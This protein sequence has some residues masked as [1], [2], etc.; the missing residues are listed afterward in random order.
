MIDLIRDKGLNISQRI[1]TAKKTKDKGCFYT[2]K[3]TVFIREYRGNKLAEIDAFCHSHEDYEILIP[4]TPLPCLV[5]DDEVVFG[6]VGF[7]Y[8]IPSFKKHGF[9]NTLSDVSYIIVVFQRDYFFNV[10]NKMKNPVGAMKS[11]FCSNIIK[12][13]IKMFQS[14]FKQEYELKE[15]MLNTIGET[16]IMEMIRQNLVEYKT[17]IYKTKEY[18]KGIQYVVTFMNNNYS[19]DHSIDTLAKMC[20]MSKYHFIRSFKKFT[21]VP[22][23]EYLYKIRC[24]RAKYLFENTNKKIKEVAKIVGFKS[25]SSFVQ[26]FKRYVGLTPYKYI[27]QVKNGGKN[28]N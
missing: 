25:S 14:I 13:L 22:P 28:E 17:V 20:G 23:L 11:F 27:S 21:S 12:D 19:Q 15:E 9:N 1:E 26:V 4:I 16:L 10:V 7:C 24:S 3:G 18:Q 6:E 8:P 2:Q 5:Q